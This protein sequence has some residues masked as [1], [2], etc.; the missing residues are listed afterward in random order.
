MKY[1]LIKLLALLPMFAV[2]L[3]GFIL[4]NL[5]F[6]YV[7]LIPVVLLDFLA[8]VILFAE[9]DRFE[10]DIKNIINILTNKH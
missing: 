3:S 9:T 8:S 1:Y 7:I 10:L 6:S 5:T 2:L 4:L